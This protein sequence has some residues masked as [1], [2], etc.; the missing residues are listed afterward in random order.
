[1]ILNIIALVWKV[2]DGVS[3]EGKINGFIRW[4]DDLI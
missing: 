3:E 4:D 1:M 2:Y